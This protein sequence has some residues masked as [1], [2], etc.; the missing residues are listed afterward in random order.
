MV[1]LLKTALWDPIWA[2]LGQ[3]GP[4]PKSSSMFFVEIAKGDHKP[5]KFKMAII[6]KLTFLFAGAQWEIYEKS[7][8]IRNLHGIVT[9]VLH[10]QFT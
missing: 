3:C 7:T 1:K 10:T 9:R 6:R 8:K 4:H 5:H 2:K